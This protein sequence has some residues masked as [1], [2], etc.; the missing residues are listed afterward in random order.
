MFQN[1]REPS[2]MTEVRSSYSSA[3]I[4][5]QKASCYTTGKRDV[6]FEEE[7]T[8]DWNLKEEEIEEG[9]WTLELD[10]SA[11]HQEQDGYRVGELE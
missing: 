6:I 3:T 9:S 4:Q 7:K 10:G 5:A 8:W 11:M 1:K 2:R